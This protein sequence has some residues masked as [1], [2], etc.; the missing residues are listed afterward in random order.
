M[1]T[2]AEVLKKIH[3]DHGANMATIG[4]TGMEDMPRV[5]TG[6]F[7]LDLAMGGGFPMSKCAIV[8]GPESSNKTNIM[9]GTIR[10]AQ[11]MFPERNAVIID[12]EFALDKKWA[13][14]QG[15]DL[16]RL[17]VVQ[18]E[19]A[20]QCV[21]FVE[22]FCYAEDVSVVGL[23]SIAALT[24]KNEIESS[25]EKVIVGGASLLVGKMY[26]KVLHSQR[27]MDNAGKAAPLFLAI[28]QIRHKIGVMFGNPETMPG[29]N[30]PKFASSMTVRTYGKN[31]VDSKVNPVMPLYKEVNCIIQKWKCPI[32]AVNAVFKMQML[33]ALGNR[34]GFVSDWNTLQAYMKELEYL[35][36]VEKGSGWV[37]HGDHYPTLDACREALYATPLLLQETK[38]TIIAELLEK[39][40]M[41][42]NA[43]DEETPA[44][45]AE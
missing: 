37:M 39:G 17:I 1:S 25:A 36:K 12:P 6:I 22:S 45:M 7:P 20:E 41:K 10:E 13:Q 44:E 4:M 27:A 29:G 16:D 33:H 3:K 26:R 42:S 40:G 21:D 30:P 24:T 14:E 34:P 43:Y 23:D 19:S 38:A 31:V 9:L 5:P 8:Y 15:V 32:L 2:S 11:V 35:S 28:N 18:P